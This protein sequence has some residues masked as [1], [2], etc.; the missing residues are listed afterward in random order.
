[1]ADVPSGLSLTSP[2]E[3]K[4]VQLDKLV[5]ILGKEEDS[6]DVTSSAEESPAGDSNTNSDYHDNWVAPL[7]DWSSIAV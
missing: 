5:F 3:T 1:V 6:I 2:E 4:K 7:H